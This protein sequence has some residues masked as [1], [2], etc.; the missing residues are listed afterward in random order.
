MNAYRVTFDLGGG[1]ELR[2][3]TPHLPSEHDAKVVACGLMKIRFAEHEIFGFTVEPL[4]GLI[5]DLMDTVSGV[6][7]Q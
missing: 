6:M 7:K 3:T 2:I 5:S 1:C 4:S